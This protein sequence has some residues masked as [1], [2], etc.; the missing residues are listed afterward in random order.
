MLTGEERKLAWSNM[1]QSLKPLVVVMLKDPA[2]EKDP[3]AEGKRVG[4]LLWDHGVLEIARNRAQS[5]YSRT[6]KHFAKIAEQYGRKEHALFYRT[7]SEQLQD[8]DQ[9][10]WVV[11]GN[12]D[13]M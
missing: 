3:V 10:E 8:P 7:I 9:D 6:F 4:A 2:L 11:V 5:H 1:L 12:D 13:F